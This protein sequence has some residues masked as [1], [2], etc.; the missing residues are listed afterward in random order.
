M[1]IMRI[2]IL[3]MLI[4][5]CAEQ[6]VLVTTVYLWRVLSKYLALNRHFKLHLLCTCS[7]VCV[8][9][10]A[11]TSACARACVS[12][13]SCYATYKTNTHNTQPNLSKHHFQSHCHV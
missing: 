8:S 7:C 1:I 11:C 9:A 12:A 6:Q 4:Y 2:T 10:R 3:N 13:D 5:V